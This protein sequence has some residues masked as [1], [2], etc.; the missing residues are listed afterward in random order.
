MPCGEH[1][2]AA[3]VM[4]EGSPATKTTRHVL[5]T[6]RFHRKRAIDRLLLFYQGQN[7]LAFPAGLGIRLAPSTVNVGIV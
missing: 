7:L 6:A 1:V 5:C 3:T 2:G 4:R